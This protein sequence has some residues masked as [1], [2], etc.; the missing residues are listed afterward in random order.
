MG[1]IL[2]CSF[3]PELPCFA[4]APSLLFPS[5]PLIRSS[6]RTRRVFFSAAKLIFISCSAAWKMSAAD[7]IYHDQ[8][9]RTKTNETTSRRRR[10]EQSLAENESREQLYDA[11]VRRCHK[12]QYVHNSTT[13]ISIKIPST[14]QPCSF[15]QSCFPRP[16][17]RPR[18]SS[19]NATI[20]SEVLLGSFSQ[21]KNEETLAYRDLYGKVQDSRS[22]SYGG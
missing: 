4:L 20:S 11:T 6:C 12:P 3:P 9:L 2:V 8:K 7:L 22:T 1:G 16:L 21:R 17:T 5:S 10:S 13:L 15:L 14:L 18:T 19:P